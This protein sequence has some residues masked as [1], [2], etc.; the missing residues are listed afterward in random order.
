MNRNFTNRINWD[1]LTMC[2]KN[3]GIGFYHLYGFNL[4]MLAKKSWKF[5]T[6]HNAIISCVFKA[7]FFPNDDF[8]GN[9][10]V[11]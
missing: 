7:K 2:K 10:F 8:F 1:G 9:S 5:T 4:V 11:P 3:E 6:N